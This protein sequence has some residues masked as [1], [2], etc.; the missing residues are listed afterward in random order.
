MEKVLFVTVSEVEK[1]E[2]HNKD[3]GKISAL[4]FCLSTRLGRVVREMVEGGNVVDQW[5]L[6]IK[7]DKLINQ[8]EDAKLIESFISKR[9]T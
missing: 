5:E 3:I 2:S 6:E 4:G 7:K 9:T 8:I 1:Y